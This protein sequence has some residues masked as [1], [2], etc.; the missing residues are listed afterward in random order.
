MLPLWWRGG[1]GVDEFVRDVDRSVRHATSVDLRVKRLCDEACVKCR[2][3]FERIDS[4]EVN[5]RSRIGAD[6]GRFDPRLSSGR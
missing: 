5:E 2:D 3:H 6:P 1:V 4:D